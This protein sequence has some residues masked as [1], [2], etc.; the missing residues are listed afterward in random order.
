M[1]NNHEHN[2]DKKWY[3][4]YAL[5]PIASVKSKD[6]CAATTHTRCIFFV[7]HITCYL[8]IKTQQTMRLRETLSFFLF[9]F[10]LLL[11][12]NLHPLKFIVFTAFK[13]SW[14]SSEFFKWI[15]FRNEKTHSTFF[16]TRRSFS[17]SNAVGCIF[18]VCV[19]QQNGTN[20]YEIQWSLL[21]N[22]SHVKW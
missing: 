9:N 6:N 15:F 11:F 13:W 19:E 7:V 10:L 12:N 18:C 2:N 5:T 14:F 17:I 16:A 22:D 20:I 1:K 4:L 21:N 3:K 8:V